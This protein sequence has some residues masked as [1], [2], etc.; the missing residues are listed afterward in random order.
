MPLSQQLHTIRW[1]ATQ[2]V[3]AELVSVT[4]MQE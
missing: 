3:L 1:G 4:T 2:R